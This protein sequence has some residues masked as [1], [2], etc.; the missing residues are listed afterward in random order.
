MAAQ[1]MVWALRVSLLRP[2]I[3]A[4]NDCPGVPPVRLRD[5][6]GHDGARDPP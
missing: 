1:I 5:M 6:H 4:T 3:V 2:S